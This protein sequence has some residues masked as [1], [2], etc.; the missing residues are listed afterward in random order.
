M[1]RSV[2]AAEK[3]RLVLIAGQPSHP[4]MMHEFRAGC[5]LL[6][7]CLDASQLI[8]TDLH[9]DGWPQDPRAFEGA[10]AVCL[11]M[12]G[13]AK[14]AA[15]QQDRLQTLSGLVGRGVG[16]GCMHYSVEVPADV[17]GKQWQD[18]IGGHYEHLYSVNPLWEP[19]F[20][21]LPA[22]PIT[23]G[24]KPFRVK[25]E[26]YF[27]MRF[28]PGMQGI[29]PILTAK[30]SD[31]VRDGPYVYPKGPY[32]HIVA[33]KGRDELLMWCVERPDGGRG[34]GFTGGHF[35][36]NWGQDDFRKIVL[37]ALTWLAKAEVP[38]GG[39]ESRVTE[40]E[41]YQNLDEKP[42]RPTGSR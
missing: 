19:E 41:L 33:A 11:Y 5:L 37:N 9:F 16:L 38:A 39:V 14:H 31:D 36:L 1:N 7:R 35:Q 20:E 28:R 34:F 40:A 6:K 32:E 2:N 21:R 10:D 15:L 4:T 8:R 3:R 17:A 12:D 25:D 24:V 23:R 27:N 22:H 18:W 30:P 26:W 13:G 42:G 29:T